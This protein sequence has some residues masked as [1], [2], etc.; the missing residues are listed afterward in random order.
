MNLI[1]PCDV[2]NDGVSFHYAQSFRP[3]DG[4]L[5]KPSMKNTLQ[6]LI[7][8]CKDVK[9]IKEYV[10][11]IYY[12]TN[13]CHLRYIGGFPDNHNVSQKELLTNW[14]ASANKLNKDSSLS[15]SFKNGTFSTCN[16][17]IF[18]NYGLSD[19]LRNGKTLDSNFIFC[20]AS[21]ETIPY[22]GMKYVVPVFKK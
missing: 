13:C 8:I 17:F 19:I 10:L 2:L 21:I 12:L 16:G 18:S 6:V 7:L 9:K 22:Q 11:S 4:G 3:P 20:K 1:L 14:R 5:K 15:V